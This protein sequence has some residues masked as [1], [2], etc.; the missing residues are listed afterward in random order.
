MSDKPNKGFFSGWFGGS[1]P[2]KT[3]GEEFFDKV[4]EKIDLNTPKEPYWQG[5]LNTFVKRKDALVRLYGG[6]YLQFK[7]IRKGVKL[8]KETKDYMQTDGPSHIKEDGIEVA[9][10]E[11]IEKVKNLDVPNV[12]EGIKKV[13]KGTS[14]VTTTTPEMIEKMTGDL[15]TMVKQMTKQTVTTIAGGFGVGML[16]AKSRK[17]LPMP[18]QAKLFLVAVGT[19]W[20]MTGLLATG[21]TLHDLGDK[22]E[23]QHVTMFKKVMEKHSK[24]V[25][26]ESKDTD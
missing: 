24:R 22:T 11:L 26:I 3:S 18:N 25:K 9:K 13:K 16:I 7:K 1:T 17:K 4:G 23:D 2:K 19:L 15:T 8:I 12:V 14:I 21:Y 5:M 20:T 10:D 6:D